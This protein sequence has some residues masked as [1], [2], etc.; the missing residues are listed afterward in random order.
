MLYADLAAALELEFPT[1]TDTARK[2]AVRWA[3][4]E[5]F[6]KSNAW[7]EMRTQSVTSGRAVIAPP[8][9]TDFL[10]LLSVDSGR[11]GPRYD[12]GQRSAIVPDRYTEVELEFSVA[13]QTSCESL[14]DGR[15]DLFEEAFLCG[16]RFWLFANNPLTRDLTAA[17]AWRNQF[18]LRARNGE[19][20]FNL[21]GQVRRDLRVTPRKF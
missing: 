15:F 17:A 16:A 21:G 5:F 18:Y 20:E 4:R 8:F 13:P 7:R 19:I 14:P 6:I 1:T 9:G 12:F 3:V 10:H 11:V 2:R